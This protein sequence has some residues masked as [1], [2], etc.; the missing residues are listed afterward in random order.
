MKI[1]RVLL[2]LSLLCFQVAQAAPKAPKAV[3]PTESGFSMPVAQVVR[4]G[5]NKFI[6][7]YSA[8]THAESTQGQMAGYSYY[9]QSKQID[10]DAHARFLSAARRQQIVSIRDD[11]G[12]LG[13]AAWSMTEIQAGGGT[14]WKLMSVGAYADR[15]DEMAGIIAAMKQP[16]QNAYAR[17]RASILLARTQHELA[18]LKNAHIKSYDGGSTVDAQRSFKMSWNEAQTATSQLRNLAA[19]LPDNT[20]REVAQRAFVEMDNADNAQN[21][22]NN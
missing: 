5:Q 4:L 15:E 3:E 8:K 16:R 14:M 12:Q 22:A 6:E 7:I 20:A 9:A 19:A 18:Q 21:D 11:L 17:R 10:N 2:G 1:A 13:D